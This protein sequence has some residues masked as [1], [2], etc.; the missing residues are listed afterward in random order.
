MR[1]VALGGSAPLAVLRGHCT[2]GGALDVREG[3]LAALALNERLAGIDGLVLPRDDDR[4]RHVFHQY[5]VR[6]TPEARLGRDDLQARLA[7][8]G[9]ASG[10][11]YP[12]PVFDYPCFRAEPRIG[13]PDVPNTVRVAREVLSLPVN[14]EL[15]EDDLELIVDAVRG[16]LG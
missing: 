11:Y 4:G 14:P 10:V 13:D 3:D 12:R 15:G 16:A 9:V 1:Y 7:E 5:T 6:V 8:R 2:A